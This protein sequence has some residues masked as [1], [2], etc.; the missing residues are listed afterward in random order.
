MKNIILSI[1]ITAI[2]IFGGIYL[3][4]SAKKESLGGYLVPTVTNASSSVG[5]ASTAVIAAGAGLQYLQITNLGAGQIFCAVGATA[6]L[7][8][9]LV[10]YATSS[11]NMF[12]TIITEP[13]I[14]LKSLNCIATVTSTI[15]ILKF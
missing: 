7:N 5:G 6:T 4:S 13:N 9:G 10:I 15:S 14:L 8:T 2:V 11:T 12:P 3:I 1:L